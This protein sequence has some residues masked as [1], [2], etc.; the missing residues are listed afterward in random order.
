[1]ARSTGLVILIK[2]IYTLWGRKHFL[3]PVTAR[4]EIRAASSVDCV[5]VPPND[6]KRDRTVAQ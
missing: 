6:C 1:M 3:L 5:F 4:Y 2:N